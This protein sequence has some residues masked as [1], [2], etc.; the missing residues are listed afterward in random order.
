[1]NWNSR[2]KW[3]WES[4]FISG[5]KVGFK[6][7]TEESCQVKIVHPLHHRSI[8]PQDQELRPAD[9]WLFAKGFHSVHGAQCK[10]LN[11]VQKKWVNNP[12][13]KVQELLIQMASRSYVVEEE[14]SAQVGKS[15]CTWATWEL[16]HQLQQRQELFTVFFWTSVSSSTP[17]LWSLWLG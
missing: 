6:I 13:S 17:S 11:S 15:H 2:E 16:C 10:K 7:K 14:V 4:N 1:M 12:K 9:L 5:E 3:R 8:T